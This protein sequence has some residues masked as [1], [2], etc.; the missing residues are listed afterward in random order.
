MVASASEAALEDASDARGAAKVFRATDR[1]PPVDGRDDARARCEAPARGGT[2]A[3]VDVDARDMARDVASR[4][5]DVGWR[6]GVRGARRAFYLFH[7]VSLYN[8]KTL[9]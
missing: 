3:A 1:A 8:T 9:T 7:V 4:A 6:R 5:R 2:L